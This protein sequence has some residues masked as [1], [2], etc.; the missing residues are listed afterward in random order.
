VY[1]TIG[2]CSNEFQEP[3]A[4]DEGNN[5]TTRRTVK[6]LHYG[7]TSDEGSYSGKSSDSSYYE[8]GWVSSGS[9]ITINDED[10][11][12]ENKRHA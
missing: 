12:P 8:S 11:T 10:S 3:E 4:W 5:F 1:A 9:T 6:H 2:T 7:Y